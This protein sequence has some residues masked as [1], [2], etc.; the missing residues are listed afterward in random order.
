MSSMP[1]LPVD[2][3]VLKLTAL[4]EK[5]VRAAFIRKT[6]KLRATKPFRKIGT[7]AEFEG[8]ANYVWRMLCFD[9]VNSPPHSCMPVTADFSIPGDYDERRG[10]TKI[11][12]ELIKRV[13]SVVP[14]TSQV[15]ALRWGS[16]I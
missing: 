11:L 15:G 13:E 1:I 8:C 10:K 6:G 16:L 2:S 5:L 7:H 9:F 14:I 4:E 3:M 12:D